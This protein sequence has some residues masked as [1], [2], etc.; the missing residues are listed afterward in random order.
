MNTLSIPDFRLPTL[1]NGWLEEKA[2]PLI[3]GA[4]NDEVLKRYERELKAAADIYEQIPLGRI[5]IEKARRIID[6]RRGELFGEAKLGGDRKSDQ[7]SS[8]RIDSED[9][10]VLS[11]CRKIA[12]HWKELWPRILE[13]TDQAAVT[14]AAVLRMTINRQKQ[15]A[16]SPKPTPKPAPRCEEVVALEDQGMSNAEISQELDIKPRRVSQILREERLRREVL[17]LITPDML[18]MTAQQKLE[19]AIRQHKEKLTVEW[20]IAVRKRVDEL[21]LNTIGPRLKKEQDQARYV[22]KHRKGIMDHKSYRK[23]WSCLHPDRILDEKL[24]PMYA[25]AFDIFRAVQKLLLDEK[26]DPTEFVG[27]P[28][29]LAE[30]DVLKRE[31][32]MARKRRATP[33]GMAVT[34]RR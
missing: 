24:K 7:F 27:V 19:A 25:E 20:S 17:P 21:L 34:Q 12:K 22:M 2:A 9:K 29:T 32:S 18:S 15:P 4:D 16:K 8:V 33:N 30:W 11:R 10:N 3:G 5:E 23:I 13:A 26:N 31:A 14:R 1:P 6:C 28:S